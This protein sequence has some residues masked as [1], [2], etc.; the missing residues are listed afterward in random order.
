MSAD[1]CQVKARSFFVFWHCWC[2]NSEC[3]FWVPCVS[4][5]R[6][7]ECDTAHSWEEEK[8]S[9]LAVQFLGCKRKVNSST[10]SFFQNLFRAERFQLLNILSFWNWTLLAHRAVCAALEKLQGESEGQKFLFRH[11]WCRSTCWMY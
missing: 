4:S 5:W 1:L 10:A 6:L 9:W 7:A 3:S 2:R 11:L 8:V